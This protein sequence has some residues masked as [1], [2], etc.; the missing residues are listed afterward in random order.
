[1]DKG[2]KFQPPDDFA[3]SNYARGDVKAALSSAPHRF[4]PDLLRHRFG[5]TT[6]WN[7]QRRWQCGKATV[8][9]IRGNAMG[10]RSAQRSGRYA[11][12][13]ARGRPHRLQLR[14]RRIRLQGI[15]LAALGLR[16]NRRAARRAAGR[17]GTYTAADVP[18]SVH[19]GATR[20]KMSLGADASGKL[21][22][23]KHES[24]GR[25]DG[26]RLHRAMRGIITG[27]L[28]D[29]ANVSIKHYRRTAQHRHPHAHARTGESPTAHWSAHS[30]NLPGSTD[31]SSGTAPEEAQRPGCRSG[32]SVFQQAST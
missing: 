14:G 3:K 4:D 9:C 27:F 28:Y 16:G 25:I 12:Y 2:E 19:R 13:A 31:G 17:V 29:C 22:A 11:G 15:C 24:Y 18:P 8:D 32:P 5:A 26:G 30:T 23:I 20:Q 7:H 10:G 6:R 1:M 21:L